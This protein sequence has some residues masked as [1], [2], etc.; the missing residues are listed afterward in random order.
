MGNP[1]L[2]K[3]SAFVNE[4]ISVARISLPLVFPGLL[5]YFPY[6]VSLYFL[7]GLGRL[8]FAGGFLALT[9]ADITGYSLFSGLTMGIG[10]ICPP[11]FG[12]KRYYLFRATIRRGII[13]L[14][15]TSIPVSLL[16]INIKKILEMLK[17]DEDL[18]SEAQTF[19]LYSVP[20]LVA[21]SFLQPLRVYQS[22]T[23]PLSICTA[24]ACVLHLPITLLLVSYLGFG[25]KGIAL[26]GVV[27]NFNLVIFLCIYIAFLEEKLSSN[28]EVLEESYEDRM[29]EWKKLLVLALPVADGND[30]GV[31]VWVRIQ[32]TLARDARGPDVLFDW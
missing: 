2:P 24:I 3:V 29:R 5:L 10:S 8:T 21:Q 1:L 9:F 23:M 28:E 16:W 15:L 17:Q 7:E 4:A 26:S 32:G 12:A 25:I 20:D 31:L 13:L 6:F 22:K 14:L 11:A 19:L 27:L 18:A 30:Y